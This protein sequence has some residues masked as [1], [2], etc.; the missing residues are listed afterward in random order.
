MLEQLLHGYGG[1]FYPS[2]SQFSGLS[3]LMGK[4][5]YTGKVVPMCIMKV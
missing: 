5:K 4:I 1:H 3:H 2:V